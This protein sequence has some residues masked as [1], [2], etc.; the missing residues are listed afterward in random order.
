M[1]LQ[2]AAGLFHFLTKTTE[3]PPTWA[4][5][6]KFGDGLGNEFMLVLHST[7]T[8]GVATSAGSPVGL[9]D[10]ATNWY[11]VTTDISQ[12]DVGKLMGMSMV[13]ITSAESL[14][15]ATYHWIMTKGR[16]QDYIAG[17]RGVPLGDAT[18]LY[19]PNVNPLTTMLT[20]DSVV[21]GG[22]IFWAADNT[23]GGTTDLGTGAVAGGLAK[24]ADGGTAMTADKVFIDVGY[25][26]A[27][28]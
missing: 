28:A 8:A 1:S 9:L 3:V 19:N 21:D 24:A 12:S 11:T 27:S 13:A 10:A 5:G 17:G 23:W 25:G 18:N 6:R 26:V 4:L 16:P 14:A 7:P 22:A 2:V 15:G 20:D